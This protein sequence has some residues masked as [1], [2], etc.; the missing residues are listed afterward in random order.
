MFLTFC[1]YCQAT[2]TLLSKKINFTPELAMKT[3][4]KS[5]CKLYSFFNLGARWGQVFNPT[6]RP[7]HP[8][9]RD[10]LP[11][12]KEVGV[13]HGHFGLAQKIPS[14]PGLDSRTVQPVASRYTDWALSPHATLYYI[15][16]YHII[17]HIIWY[18][19][20][21]YIISYIISDQIT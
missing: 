1:L 4:K 6:P 13:P 17:Y 11:I 21:Y 10:P 20:I 7:L 14:P 12:V 2:S 16:S 9:E 3:Q 8:R 15:A 19:M 18:Y 5:R